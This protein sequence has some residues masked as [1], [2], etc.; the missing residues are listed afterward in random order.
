MGFFST[1]LNVKIF[2]LSEV[3]TRILIYNIYVQK[4]VAD[5]LNI[6]NINFFLN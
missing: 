5:L 4:Y 6:I 2:F 3:I 1:A